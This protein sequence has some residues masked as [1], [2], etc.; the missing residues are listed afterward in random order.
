MKTRTLDQIGIGILAL[1]SVVLFLTAPRAGDFIWSE[2][3][4]NALDGA[5]V[6]DLL[7][8]M[9]LHD[10]FGWASAYYLK[11]PSLTILFYP[12]LLHAALAVF[13]AVF[14]VSHAAAMA[15]ITVFAFSLAAGTYVLSRR[16]ATPLAALAGALL[17]MAAPELIRWG[18]QV[19]LEVPMMAL[20]TWSAVFTARYGDSRRAT[21]LAKAAFFIVAAMYT[22]QTAATI[23]VGLA[24]GLLVS[25]GPELLTRRHVWIITAIIAVSLIPLALMTL[26]FGAF[27]VVSVVHRADIN[28]PNRLSWAGI[29]WYA[30]RAF[31]M[32]G[33]VVVALASLTA[34]NWAAR[35]ATRPNRVDILTLS[36]WLLVTYVALTF[37]DLKETRHALPLLVPVAVLASA[38]I[39]L[40]FPPGA[41]RFTSPVFASCIF[42]WVLWDH[43]TVGV[44]GYAQAAALI[45]R[46]APPDARVLFSGNRDGAFVFDI[47]ALPERHDIAVVRADKLFLNVRVMP[48]LGLHPKKMDSAE[49]SHLLNRIGISYVVAV[50]NQWSQAPIMAEFNALL[51]SPQFRLV[52]RIPVTGPSAERALM[53]YRNTGTLSEPPEP[54]SANL[55]VVGLHLGPQPSR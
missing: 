6:L 11:Y 1:A 52:E 13:F 32:F 23:A 30:R 27:D 24:L 43:P 25:C 47:R 46:V 18:Q 28:V 26:R 9:P 7:R 53:V 34:V 3:P 22:K 21:D 2:S 15:C 36:G 49:I 51:N 10:P 39:D 50:P 40:V 44:T 41:W 38:A 14:G 45:G 20:A 31:Q 16:I 33:F 17:L 8:A 29:T 35:P 48:G 42:G 37:I 12:P 5:F 4:R 55:P 54:L 19:M